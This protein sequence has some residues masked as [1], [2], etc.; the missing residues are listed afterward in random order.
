[1]A[2]L[3]SFPTACFTTVP[4]ESAQNASK[5][6][7][8]MVGQITHRPPP[9]PPAPLREN[10]DGAGRDDDERQERDRA[11]EHHQHLGPPRERQDI[12]GLNAVAVLY[13]RDR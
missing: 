6:S 1:M 3:G 13:P 7:A 9:T 5:P 8:C 4:T 12:G 11:F 2:A 10:V